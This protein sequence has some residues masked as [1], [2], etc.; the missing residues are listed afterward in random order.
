MPS[1]SDFL[2]VKEAADEIQRRIKEVRYTG[3][4]ALFSAMGFIIALAALIVS[5]IALSSS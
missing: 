5:V 4:I 1:G 2:E 3:W